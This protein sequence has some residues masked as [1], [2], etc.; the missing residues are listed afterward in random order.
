MGVGSSYSYAGK[1]AATD[2]TINPEASKTRSITRACRNCRAHD[3]RNIAGRCVLSR[4][5]SGALSRAL[6]VRRSKSPEPTIRRRTCCLRQP[7]SRIVRDQ[8]MV[9]AMNV[10]RPMWILAAWG[11]LTAPALAD[12]FDCRWFIPA[13]DQTVAVPCAEVSP[14]P[15]QEVRV[16]QAPPT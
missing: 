7:Y 12:D 1:A 5:A 16:E 11:M 10:S 2:A 9:V 8:R 15:E 13:A 14:P 6:H 4:T 3:R